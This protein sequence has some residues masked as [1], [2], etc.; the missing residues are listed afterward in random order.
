MLGCGSS[1]RLNELSLHNKSKS[2][3]RKAQAP[4]LII[5]R[6]TLITFVQDK[7]KKGSPSYQVQVNLFINHLIF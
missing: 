5:Y 4:N 7:V 3:Q 1:A 2:T 6:L